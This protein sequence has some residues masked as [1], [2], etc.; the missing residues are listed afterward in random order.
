MRDFNKVSG[1]NTFRFCEVAKCV[2]IELN[3]DVEYVPID[4]KNG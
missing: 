1:G 4:L 3:P 2:E